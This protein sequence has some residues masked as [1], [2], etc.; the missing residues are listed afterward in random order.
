MWYTALFEIINFYKNKRLSLLLLLGFC[1]FFIDSCQDNK[2]KNSSTKTKIKINE[3]KFEKRIQKPFQLNKDNFL[4]FFVNYGSRNLENK[5]R[6][7]TT[8]G[9]IEIEL[10]K[11][12]RFHRANFIYLTKLN[13]FE[14][15]QFYRVINN[16]MIQGGNSDDRKIA[17]KRKQIGRYLLPNDQN[18]NFKHHRGVLSMPSSDIENPYKLASPFEFFIVQQKEGAHH[19]DGNYTIFGKVIKGMDVVDKIAAEKTDAADWPLQN[20]YITKVDIIN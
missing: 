13:Y 4:D 8:L 7:H 20:I 18:Y 11:E 3:T 14:N 5:V 10:F 12:T 17:L 9:N 1:L 2:S 15:T 19:L 6:L 16:F